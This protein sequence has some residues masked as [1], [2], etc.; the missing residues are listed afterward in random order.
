LEFSFRVAGVMFKRHFLDDCVAVFNLEKNHKT[1]QETLGSYNV[2]DWEITVT[3]RTLMHCQ[4]LRHQ[5]RKVE[6][7]EKYLNFWSNQKE[8]TLTLWF[9]MRGRPSPSPRSQAKTQSSLMGI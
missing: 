9:C 7:D 5:N 2:H 3:M 4:K 8:P 6:V 1:L